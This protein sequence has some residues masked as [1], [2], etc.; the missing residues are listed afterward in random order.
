MEKADRKTAREV[1]E[2]RLTMPD[3]PSSGEKN[4]PEA[5]FPSGGP[6]ERMGR[7]VREVGGKCF[8][9]DPRDQLRAQL[10]AVMAAEN[11]ARRLKT[12]GGDMSREDICKIRISE[13]VRSLLVPIRQVPGPDC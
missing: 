3:H 6:A 2:Y 12:L 9:H 7:S 13:P 11:F 5:V 4:G 10:A 1:F 8:H